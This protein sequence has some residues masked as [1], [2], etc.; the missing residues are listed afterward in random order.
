M[1]DGTTTRPRGIMALP[2]APRVAA[3][4]VLLIG[5]VTLVALDPDGWGAAGIG[6]LFALLSAAGFDVLQRRDERLGRDS[7]DTRRR[8]IVFFAVCGVLVVVLL[9]IKLLR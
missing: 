4:V 2:L 5:C 6:G 8:R 3:L 1:S 9:V 7:S